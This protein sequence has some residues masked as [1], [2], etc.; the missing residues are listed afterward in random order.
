MSITKHTLEEQRSALAK[1]FPAN[2]IFSARDI[3]DKNFFKLLEGY[4]KEFVRMECAMV[5]VQSQQ[6]PENTTI[7]IEEWEKSLGI[8]DDCFDVNGTIEERR[9]NIVVKFALMNIQT[10]PDFISLAATYGFEIEISNLAVNTFTYTFP[11]VFATGDP[12]EQNFV[13][14]IKFLNATPIDDDAFPYIFP[15]VFAEP[16]VNIIQ[17]LFNKLKPVDV[18]LVFEFA[19]P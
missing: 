10:R 1:F 18:E 17:C 7:F 8:P 15:I 3:P 19:E 5:E 13:V 9:L 2:C 12:L 11:I 14:I 4:A 16:N 6:N